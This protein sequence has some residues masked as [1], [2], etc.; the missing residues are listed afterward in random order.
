MIKAFQ[1]LAAMGDTDNIATV[2]S[3]LPDGFTRE[4]RRMANRF[5]TWPVSLIRCTKVGQKA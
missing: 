5:S 4:A 3:A 2:E 1:E